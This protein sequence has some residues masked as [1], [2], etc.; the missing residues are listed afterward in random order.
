LKF[1]ASLG[2]IKRTA[3]HRTVHR[4]QVAMLAQSTPKDFHSPPALQL[5]ADSRDHVCT[6]P[7]T[8]QNRW[9]K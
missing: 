2:V 6:A 7:G 8:S 3:A 5:M 9:E 1:R 4:N